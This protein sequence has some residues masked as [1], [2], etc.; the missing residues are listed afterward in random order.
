[1][2][3]AF[4]QVLQRETKLGPQTAE[5]D[6]EAHMF[7]QFQASMGLKGNARPK[8]SGELASLLGTNQWDE[9]TPLNKICSKIMH[10]TV[11]SIA[12]N[13]VQGSLDAIIPFL[14]DSATSDLLLI[15]S[16]IKRHMETEGI[17][18]PPKKTPPVAPKVRPKKRKIR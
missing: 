4:D 11:F 18:V 3:A 13:T 9:F 1:M 8:T 14:K 16:Q 6:S 10:R 15:Y 2:K 17:Q 12:S 5:S 7:Q